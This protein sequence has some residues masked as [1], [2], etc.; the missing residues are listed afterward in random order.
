MI[1]IRRLTPALRK[2]L[3]S[4]LGLLIRGS[5]D[6]TMK[7]LERL[8]NKEKSS[9][10]ISVGDVVSENMMKHGIQPHVWVVDHKVMRESVTPISIEGAQVLHVK[11]PPGTLTEEAWSVMREALRTRRLTKVLVDGEEDLFTMVAVLCAPQNSFVIY[12]QPEEGIV[13]VKVTREKREQVRRV[14]EAMKPLTK[15]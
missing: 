2:E 3:I 6:E 13:V 7:K 11:N 15:S 1:K 14:V 5:F 10:I 12:G 8:V 9:W 4:P